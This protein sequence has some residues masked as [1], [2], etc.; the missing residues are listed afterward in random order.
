MSLEVRMSKPNVEELNFFVVFS[1]LI[2]YKVI[3]WRKI[4]KRGATRQLPLDVRAE[5]PPGLPW[6][7]TLVNQI[8]ILVKKHLPLLKK[9][10]S[11]VPTTI[12]HQKTF[13]FEEFRKPE[14][15]IMVRYFYYLYIN[16]LFTIKTI[17]ISPMKSPLKPFPISRHKAWR[18]RQT[19]LTI[20]PISSKYT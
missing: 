13:M 18:T 14:T 9:S 3:R 6:H 17:Q 11:I 4:R 1:S 2:S 5:V 20:L 10:L 16:M 15:F 19:F 8:I 7:P 12:V